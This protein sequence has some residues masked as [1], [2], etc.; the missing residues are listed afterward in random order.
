MLSTHS[1]VF[2]EHSM[3]I[4]FRTRLHIRSSEWVS[5]CVY[6]SATGERGKGSGCLCVCTGVRQE[7]GD[8][9]VGVYVCVQEC[10]RREGKREW[11]D[12]CEYGEGKGASEQT[13][14]YVCMRV[15]ARACQNVCVRARTRARLCLV[16]IY[17]VSV[18]FITSKYIEL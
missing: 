1:R 2:E 13:C 6:R 10:D 3:Y 5:V 4:I 17:T 18:S 12:V 11:V 16:K 15:R 7:R 14:A 8:K 9:G